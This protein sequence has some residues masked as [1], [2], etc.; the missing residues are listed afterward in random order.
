MTKGTFTH[1][2]QPQLLLFLYQIKEGMHDL[3]RLDM[4]LFPAKIRINLAEPK[5]IL[6]ESTIF[7]EL[8]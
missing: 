3:Q 5:I 4:T 1:P 8:K 7:R 2:I 6:S